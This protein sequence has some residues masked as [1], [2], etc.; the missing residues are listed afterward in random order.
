MAR[1][2]VA[3]V[4]CLRFGLRIVKTRELVEEIMILLLI[5]KLSS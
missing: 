4:D 1:M 5:K 2:R 3:S